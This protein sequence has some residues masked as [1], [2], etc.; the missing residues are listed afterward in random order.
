MLRFSAKGT[1]GLHNALFVCGDKARTFSGSISLLAGERGE[2]DLSCFLALTLYHTR[3][4]ISLC[5]YVILATEDVSVRFVLLYDRKQGKQEK[6]CVRESFLF[7]GLFVWG[8]NIGVGAVR[9]EKSCMYSS[10][11]TIIGRSSRGAPWSAAVFSRACS[12]ITLSRC[13]GGGGYSGRDETNA[14]KKLQ[15]GRVVILERTQGRT[16]DP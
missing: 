9:D 6:T 4:I 11:S 5:S 3:Y 14:R 13:K 16:N 12:G 7:L 2:A 8:A 10:K 1:R 15:I